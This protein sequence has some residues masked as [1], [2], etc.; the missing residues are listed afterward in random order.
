MFFLFLKINLVIYFLALELT[1]VVCTIQRHLII[2]FL[3]FIVLFQFQ[4]QMII[5]LL[6]TLS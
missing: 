5:F 4:F 6:F 2:Y 3:S 1:A